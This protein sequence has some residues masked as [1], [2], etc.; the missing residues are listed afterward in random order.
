MEVYASETQAT[1]DGALP[2][3]LRKAIGAIKEAVPVE[4]YAATLTELRPSGDS[5]RGR[6]PVHKG[7]NEGAFLV[8]P[9]RRRWHCFRCAE[10][11]DVIDLCQAVEGGEAWEAII[12]L[13]ERFD[14][15]LPRR[16]ERWHE[17]NTE[18]GRRWR[19]L[20]RWR[21]ARYQRRLYRLFA[22]DAVAAIPD[23]DERASEA[24]RQWDEAGGLA[25]TW[26]AR[27]MGATQ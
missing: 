24:R 7:D 4:T 5:L 23:A 12:S 6:C 16:S 2:Y 9:D 3:T 1:T 25:R 22:A 20:R 13:V 18:K 19:E 27:S 26:A 14:V 11:G 8:D 21:A 15:K 10:G 17:H